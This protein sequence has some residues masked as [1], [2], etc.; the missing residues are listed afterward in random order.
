MEASLLDLEESSVVIM[1][2]QQGRES[3]SAQLAQAKQLIPSLSPEAK[4][5]Q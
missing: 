4:A 5:W 1:D 2:R 3:F